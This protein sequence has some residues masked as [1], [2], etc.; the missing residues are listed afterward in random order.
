MASIMLYISVVL[1]SAAFLEIC[2]RAYVRQSTAYEEHRQLYHKRRWRKISVYQTKMFVLFLIG[3]VPIIVLYGLR[4]GIGTDYSA[5]EAIYKQLHG[6]SLTEYWRLHSVDFGDY[7]VEIGYFLLNKISFSYVHLQFMIILLM[8]CILFMVLSRYENK[9]SKGMA[10]FIFLSTQFIYA[11]NGTRF[12]M[13]AL[14]LLWAYTKIEEGKKL[15]FLV[16]TVCAVLF[17]KSALICCVF[18]LLKEFSG[19]LWNKLR[20]FTVIAAIILLP[21]A[22]GTIMGILSR[23]SIFSRYFSADIYASSFSMSGGGFMW[24]MHI[25]PVLLPIAFIV[26][27]EKNRIDSEFKIFFRICCMEI[28]LRMLS[29][30]NPWYGRLARYAQIAQ[31]ILIPYFLGKVKSKKLRFLLICYYIAWYIFYFL[32][33]LIIIDEKHS[34]PYQTIF[35]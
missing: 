26:L 9:V 24:L 29:F 17:H 14:F 35:K 2:Q 23:L 30:F 6:V 28:P 25:V 18:Y 1:L 4:Y 7:Y 32:Y 8:A 15:E 10:V 5:Y 20:N 16:L 12:I 22:L 27:I 34:L 19:S 33:Y 3:M 21:A 13:A 11:M 31:C